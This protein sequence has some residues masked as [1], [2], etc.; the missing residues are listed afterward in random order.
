MTRV[1]SFLLIILPFLAV[2]LLTQ[3][4][5]P[6]DFDEGDYHIPVIQQFADSLPQPDLMHYRSATTPLMHLGLAVWGR[7]VGTE[8]WKLRVIMVLVGIAAAFAFRQIL[9]E[10]SDPAVDRNTL[11]LIVYPYFFWLSFIVMT[12]VV[13]LLF[14]L[15]ALRYALRP[16]PDRGD[17]ARFAIW[18]TLAIFTRQQ[19]LFL[20][21][22][23]AP[24]W[25]WQDRNLSRA[26]W[27]GIPLLVIAPLFIAWGGLNP[28]VFFATSHALVFNPAQFALLL[29]FVGFYFAPAVM[30]KATS[31]PWRRLWPLGLA[32]LPLLLY[33]PHVDAIPES[34][35]LLSVQR[36]FTGNLA[37]FGELA[38]RFLP[39][40][41]VLAGYFV[42]LLLGAVILVKA[43]SAHRQAQAGLLWW[44]I[45]VFMLMT[46]LVAQPWERYFL[47]I[48]PLLIL[49]L[50]YPLRT[51][52]RLLQGW[53][54][55]QSLL[56]VGFL[57]YQIQGTVLP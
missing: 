43:W 20:P 10:Q 5:H 42:L 37:R 6:T 54:V 40:A 39:P 24:Y 18:A 53:L 55:F 44:L 35:S 14:G 36:N 16:R 46:A 38:A 47:P 4:N 45:A 57:A 11:F 52:R 51:H 50:F 12:E 22:A 27:A 26:K 1:R 13:A 29:I 21:L 3:L 9:I 23:A 49:L 33:A 2:A 56:L 30:A 19:W 25:L 34:W 8:P 48:V 7:M 28:P 17:L 32:L 41:V 15:L 31:W